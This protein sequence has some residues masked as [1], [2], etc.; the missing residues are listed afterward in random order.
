MPRFF[1]F[2]NDF[3]DIYADVRSAPVAAPPVDTIPQLKD[4]FERRARSH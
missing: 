4:V 3:V 2:P 1:P